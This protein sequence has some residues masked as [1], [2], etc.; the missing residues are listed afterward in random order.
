MLLLITIMHFSC[1]PEEIDR[2]RQ[3]R[4]SDLKKEKII[5]FFNQAT[6]NHRFLL[7][8]L[9]TNGES[10]KYR[11]NLDIRLIKFMYIN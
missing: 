4:A 7:I 2:I 9:K 1:I 11:K 10:L 8:D 3:N 6:K 5:N